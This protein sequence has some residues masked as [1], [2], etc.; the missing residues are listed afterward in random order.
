MISHRDSFGLLA[1]NC[2]SLLKQEKE[3]FGAAGNNNN[4]A[5]LS[6]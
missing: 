6:L 1:N 5:S 4:E 3:G 2:V